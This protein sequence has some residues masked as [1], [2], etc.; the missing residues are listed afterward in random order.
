VRTQR[1]QSGQANWIASGR[2]GDV[3]RIAGSGLEGQTKW[4]RGSRRIVAGWR[5]DGSE[6]CSLFCSRIPAKRH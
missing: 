5:G 6:G 4:R 1:S 2:Y 3:G